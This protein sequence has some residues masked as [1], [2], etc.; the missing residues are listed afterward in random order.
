MQV[1]SLEEQELALLG[2]YIRLLLHKDVLS[3]SSSALESA[4][5]IH[6]VLTSW[7]ARVRSMEQPHPM[8]SESVTA[9]VK[10][11]SSLASVGGSMSADLLQ[12]MRASP[13]IA[14]RH[15]SDTSIAGRHH[16]TGQWSNEPQRSGC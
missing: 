5:R 6:T 8:R 9:L 11:A 12:V 2:V 10:A 14:R 1:G 15:S 3:Q 16:T 4:K 13:H 7:V